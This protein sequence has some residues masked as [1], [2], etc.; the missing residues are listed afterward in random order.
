M[1][2]SS[3]ASYEVRGLLPGKQGTEQTLAEMAK[4]VRR[5]SIDP[6]LVALSRKIVSGVAPHDERGEVQAVY[7]YVKRAIRYVQDPADTEWVQDTR[8]SLDF[9][10]GDCD[11]KA[12][13]LASLLGAIGYLCRF[14]V[15]SYEADPLAQYDHVWVQAPINGQYVDLDASEDEYVGWRTDG[16]SRLGCY[17]IFNGQ[18]PLSGTG[19]GMEEDFGYDDLSFTDTNSDPFTDFG[20]DANDTSTVDTSLFDGYDPSTGAFDLGGFTDT[21]MDYDPTNDPNYLSADDSALFDYLQQNFGYQN[22]TVD[23]FSLQDIGVY[24]STDGSYVTVNPD[25]SLSFY[26]NTGAQIG[27]VID[28]NGNPISA[29]GMTPSAIKQ[30]AQTAANHVASSSGSGGGSGGGLPIGGAPKASTPTTPTTA[31][32]S[33]SKTINDITNAIKQALGVTNAAGITHAALPYGGINP[34]TGRPYTT[35]QLGLN[36][37]GT[38]QIS[39][40]MVALLVGAFLLLKR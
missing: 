37:A 21:S 39:I 14:A 36:Q 1:A 29:A 16:C 30:V 33:V 4:I 9:G 2:Y 27:Q 19:L 25:G 28:T 26:T 5:D 3:P 8:R 24:V 7:D 17:E 23:D 20:F 34:I 12:T 15:C 18:G 6:G 40:T 11:D 32:D 10:A 35:S 31:T 13:A 22:T 38:G